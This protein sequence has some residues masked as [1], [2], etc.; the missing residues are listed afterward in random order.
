MKNK[1]TVFIILTVLNILISCGKAP[2]AIAEKGSF[3]KVEL[4]GYECITNFKSM[5]WCER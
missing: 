3:Q 1:N 2:E 5:L 4:Y